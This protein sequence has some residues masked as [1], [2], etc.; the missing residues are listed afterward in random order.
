[1]T[2]LFTVCM[3]HTAD[4]LDWQAQEM[5]SSAGVW[6]RAVKAAAHHDAG[7]KFLSC[8]AYLGDSGVWSCTGY[9]C[10]TGLWEYLVV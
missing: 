6:Q 5:S 7:G 3:P 9:E 1:M 8:I 10:C 2:G 4:E